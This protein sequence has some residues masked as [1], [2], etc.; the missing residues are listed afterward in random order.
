MRKRIWVS[1]ILILIVCLV[2]GCSSQHEPAPDVPDDVQEKEIEWPKQSITF[3]LGWSAGGGADIT[4]R[5]VFHPFVEEIL[6]QKIVMTYMEGAGGE[7]SFIELKNS[8]PDGYTFAWTTTPT[9]PS[10]AITRGADYTL[11]D[12]TWVANISYDPAII[13]VAN[14]SP[15][16]TIEDLINYSKENPGELT[17]S[18]G[19]TGG[20]DHIAAVEFARVAGIEVTHVPFAGTGEQIPALLGGHVNAAVVKETEASSHVESGMVAVLGVMDSKR[21]KIYPDVPTLKEVGYEVISG[22]SRGFAAPPGTPKEI[23]EKMSD[24]VRQ[25]FEDPN[26]IKVAEERNITLRYMGPDEYA[27]FMAD[28]WTQLEQ[29]LA[30]E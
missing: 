21:S 6:G 22:S 8:N 28:S 20:S 15:F 2:V 13:I 30:L 11:D 26:F 10:H 24:A 16:K 29:A 9:L 19:G 17:I 18:N 25:V 23:V 4:A 12:F 3:L 7:R 5:A 27:K 1:I 14:N